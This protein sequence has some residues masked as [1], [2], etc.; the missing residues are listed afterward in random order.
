MEKKIALRPPEIPGQKA[1]VLKWGRRVCHPVGTSARNSFES[2]KGDLGQKRRK[3]RVTFRQSGSALK[4]KLSSSGTRK[5][6]GEGGGKRLG[7]ASADL[8]RGGFQDRR[9]SLAREENLAE[10]KLG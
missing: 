2:S 6:E 1:L 8:R 3:E 10:R 7:R 4:K 9:V 5:G